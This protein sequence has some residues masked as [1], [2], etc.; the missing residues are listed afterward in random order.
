M[1]EF[2]IYNR[3]ELLRD[4]I[5]TIIAWAEAEGSLTD[6]AAY[7]FKMGRYEGGVMTAVTTIEEYAVDSEQMP[8]KI[9]VNCDYSNNVHAIWFEADSESATLGVASY[10]NVATYDVDTGTYSLL[11][12][13]FGSP[14]P[15]VIAT[16]DP[17]ED[18]FRS[19]ATNDSAGRAFISHFNG[20]SGIINL[21]IGTIWK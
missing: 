11:D 20:D 13:V 17:P 6:P 15:A 12:T 18:F 1:T 3:P 14:A 9:Y 4:R 8:A 19:D 16:Y 21:T 2:R 5:Y 7:R 10:Y